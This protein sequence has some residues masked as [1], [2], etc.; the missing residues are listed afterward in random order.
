LRNVRKSSSRTHR[1]RT[2]A[3]TGA[4]ASLNPSVNVIAESALPYRQADEAGGDALQR[5]DQQQGPSRGA[6]VRPVRQ[7]AAS[8]SMSARS[9]SASSRGQQRA[10]LGEARGEPG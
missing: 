4:T 2:P 7:N 5:V 3:D 9:S 10:K 8:A 1:S 6:S